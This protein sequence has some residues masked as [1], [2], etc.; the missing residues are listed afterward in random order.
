[1]HKIGQLVIAQ[2]IQTDPSACI[3]RVASLM[4]EAVLSNGVTTKR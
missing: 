4:Y 1:M 3:L 2:I